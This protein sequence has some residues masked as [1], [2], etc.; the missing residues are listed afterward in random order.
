MEDTMIG[1]SGEPSQRNQAKNLGLRG[2]E[3][4]SKT[5]CFAP[6]AVVIVYPKLGDLDRLPMTRSRAVWP[7]YIFNTAYIPSRE[8]VG[9]KFEGVEEVTPESMTTVPFKG[10]SLAI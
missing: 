4:H 6:P 7:R 3:R 1:M 10:Q 8:D 9:K 2:P 5:S